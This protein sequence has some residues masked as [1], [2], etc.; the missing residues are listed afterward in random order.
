MRAKALDHC[1]GAVA[2]PRKAI[3]RFCLAQVNDLKALV[4]IACEV[5]EDW[6]VGLKTLFVICPCVS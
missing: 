2:A 3:P 1:S 4:K 5:R 6:I